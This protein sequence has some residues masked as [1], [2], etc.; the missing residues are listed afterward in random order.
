MGS[1]S[2]SESRDCS[3]AQRLHGREMGW[4]NVVY[5]GIEDRDECYGNCGSDVSDMLYVV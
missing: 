2:A 4:I 3:T 1:C 5:D